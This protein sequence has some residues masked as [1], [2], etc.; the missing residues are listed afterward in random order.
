MRLTPPMIES[1]GTHRLPD[2]RLGP[3]INLGNNLTAEKHQNP[4]SR[5]TKVEMWHTTAISACEGGSELPI[6][7]FNQ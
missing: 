3:R 6:G 5:R 2:S 7:G 1:V 4:G